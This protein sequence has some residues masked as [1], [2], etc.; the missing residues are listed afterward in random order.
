MVECPGVVDT[1]QGKSMSGLLE[2]LSRPTVT[3]VNHAHFETQH[4]VLES[5]GLGQSVARLR[6]SK[7]ARNE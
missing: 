1:V 3:C 5:D 2:T 6:S 7:R 4:I